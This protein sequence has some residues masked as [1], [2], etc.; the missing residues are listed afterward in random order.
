MDLS[1]PD[2]AKALVDEADLKLLPDL[3][4]ALNKLPAALVD[5]LDGLTITVTIARKVP[6]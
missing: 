3:I 4:A 5:Q 1:L 6:S 2:A